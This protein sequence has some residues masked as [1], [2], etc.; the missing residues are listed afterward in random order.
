MKQ[1]RMSVVLKIARHFL[2]T[3][4]SHDLKAGPVR[5]SKPSIC[6]VLT[7]YRLVHTWSS[8]ICPSKCLLWLLS[9]IIQQKHHTIWQG[10]TTICEASSWSKN[11]SACDVINGIPTWTN[12]QSFSCHVTGDFGPPWLCSGISANRSRKTV[13]PRVFP[14]PPFPHEYWLHHGI[15]SNISTWTTHGRGYEVG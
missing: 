14:N 3:Y 11:S 15:K 12:Q 10:M 13:V 9:V 8:Y 4:L 7:T 2:L 1:R 5:S 6:S